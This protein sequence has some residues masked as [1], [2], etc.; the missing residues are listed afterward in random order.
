MDLAGQVDPHTL[1]RV[2]V[3]SADDVAPE[4]LSRAYVQRLEM[5]HVNVRLAIIPDAQ[6]D[7][8]LDS[9]VMLEIASLIAQVR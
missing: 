1:V 6:H 8:L 9:R 5:R 7:I 4:A 3:G 2:V